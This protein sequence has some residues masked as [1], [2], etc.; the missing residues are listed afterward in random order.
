MSIYEEDASTGAAS[1]GEPLSISIALNGGDGSGEKEAEKVRVGLI[2]VDVRTG[3]AVHDTF[4]EDS[5]QRQELHTR[6]RHLRSVGA[7]FGGR[8]SV[9]LSLGPRVGGYVDERHFICSKNVM[10]ASE[11]VSFQIHGKCTFR[12]RR[13]LML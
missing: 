3:K 9:F 4:E 6:L 11:W 12:V 1:R 2:A 7:G 10:L 8:G 5:G 13:H